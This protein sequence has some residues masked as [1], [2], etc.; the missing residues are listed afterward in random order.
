MEYVKIKCTE[1]M[2][3]QKLLQIKNYPKELYVIGN[4]ELLNKKNTLAIIG[5]RDCTNY[6][7]KSATYFASEL[8]KEDICIVSGM[9]IGIDASAHIGALENT[10]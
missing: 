1:L 6:G 9:A 4:K 2:Y 7:R 5:S 10:R 3:P 8:S